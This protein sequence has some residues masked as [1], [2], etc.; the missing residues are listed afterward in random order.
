MVLVKRNEFDFKATTTVTMFTI[1]S[2]TLH[3]RKEFGGN[4]VRVVSDTMFAPST[5]AEERLKS[6]LPGD[7]EISVEEE[8]YGS[9]AK[10]VCEN[11]EE[12]KKVGLAIAG[13]QEVAEL[14]DN[15]RW[16]VAVHSCIYYDHGDK[17]CPDT[18]WDK[19]AKELAD[20]QEAF[21]AEAGTWK[22]KAF[23]DFSGDTGYHLP[24]TKEVKEAAM[25]AIEKYNQENEEG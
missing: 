9:V 14:I 22:N 20:L 16:F 17:V 23:E 8:G 25:S 12:E 24:R 2:P 11:P 13:E 19:K 1:Q 21:G 18:I 4:V 6:L 3:E 15:I 5:N 10:I 7:F